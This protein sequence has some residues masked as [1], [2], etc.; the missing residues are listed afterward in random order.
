MT[1]CYMF[2]HRRSDCRHH[3][4]NQSA[5]RVVHRRLVL[6]PKLRCFVKLPICVQYYIAHVDCQERHS[7]AAAAIIIKYIVQCNTGLV[8]AGV[9]RRRWSAPRASGTAEECIL[10]PEKKACAS[11]IPYTSFIP[12]VQI[13]FDKIIQKTS[14]DLE[15][16]SN[17]L[18]FCLSHLAALLP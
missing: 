2:E 4:V 13:R 5:K 15:M 1:Q 17:V 16:L 14:D 9:D 11:N 8:M 7:T 12:G 6:P 18:F 3:I 10:L